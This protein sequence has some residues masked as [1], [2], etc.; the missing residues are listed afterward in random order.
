MSTL[1]FSSRFFKKASEA[2][3]V[4]RPD[5]KNPDQSRPQYDETV[6]SGFR[7]I[8]ELDTREGV[9]Q[10]EK[11]LDTQAFVYQIIARTADISGVQ[12]KDVISTASGT[13]IHI[14]HIDKFKGSV[15]S[16]LIGNNLADPNIQKRR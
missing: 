16:K 9:I 2:L 7:G 8:V 15:Y 10:S 13:E 11:G 3:T 12:N 5:P 1:R 4:K 14:I 6:V